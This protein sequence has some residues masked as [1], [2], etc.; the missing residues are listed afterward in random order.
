MQGCG[1][2][3]R[4]DGGLVLL[5]AVRRWFVES[6]QCH[7]N[8]SIARFSQRYFPSDLGSKR[9]EEVRKQGPL[10]SDNNEGKRAPE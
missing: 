1:G 6:P 3:V 4:C 8:I 5:H 10:A 7:P 9:L 2:G